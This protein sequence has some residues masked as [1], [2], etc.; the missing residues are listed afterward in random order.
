MAVLGFSSEQWNSV[1]SLYS[2]ANTSMFLLG[3]LAADLFPPRK[4]LCFSFSAVGLLS[5]WLA[6]FPAYGTVKVIF[7]L[8]GIFSTL[9][10]WAALIKIIRQC[11][12]NR[13]EGKAFGA[14]EG[15]RALIGLLLTTATVALFGFFAGKGADITVE[16][17]RTGVRAV[18]VV[19]AVLC[20]ISS[21]FVFRLFKDEPGEKIDFN[22][23]FKQVVDCLT[24]PA[25]WFISFIYLVLHSATLGSIYLS[26]LMG[27]V[28]GATTAFAAVTAVFR[29]YFRPVAAFAGGFLSDRIGKAKTMI[30]ISAVM[31]ASYAFC[32]LAA[33]NAT[34]RTGQTNSIMMYGVIAFSSILI[35]AIALVRGQYYALLSEGRVP[36][37]YT[38]LA[39]GVI[40]SIGYIGDVFAPRI[41]GSFLN[42]F[43]TPGITPDGPRIAAPAAFQY[44]FY[45]SI[46]FCVCAII[47][48]AAFSKMNRE[49]SGKIYADEM[50]DG[51]KNGGEFDGYEG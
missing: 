2:A 37:R 9:T 39:V 44:I 13:S 15:G 31:I 29:N 43:S 7:I 3:G 21:F 14:L 42:T 5:L 38:G 1:M 33:S 10:F 32:M 47:L 26:T 30:I 45:I 25:V 17:A 23:Q 41:A 20:L 11:T 49:N 35:L 12:G 6:A 22:I 16:S 36:M 46:G 40:T 19:Y 8:I 4:L 18:I 48:L 27:D 24:N 28:F 51:D 50:L 34:N